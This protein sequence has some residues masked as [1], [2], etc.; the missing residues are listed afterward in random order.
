M[1]VIRRTACPRCRAV[2]GDNSGD[3]LVHYSDGGS[4][5]FTCKY[6]ILSCAERVR[7]GLPVTPEQEAIAEITPEDIEESK[8]EGVSAAFV[9]KLKAS[10][11]LRGRLY[12]GISDKSYERYWVLHEYDGRGQVFRQFYPVFKEVE[13]VSVISRFK[14]R[15]HP[16]TFSSLGMSSKMEMF[17]GE[18]SFARIN[19]SF[20]I[21]TAGEIDALSAHTMLLG[22]FGDVP[23]VCPVNG[24][25]STTQ[26]MTRR[27][28][29][30][31]R[32]EHVLL[33][34]DE[35]KAGL[36]QASVVCKDKF[37]QENLKGKL[38]DVKLSSCR[39]LQPLLISNYKCDLNVILTSGYT[40]QF[41]N[42][43]KGLVC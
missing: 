17:F 27:I 19:S 40:S 31:N 9:R 39:E 34:L 26:T 2:G 25:A 22:E 15:L 37:L 7:R 23:C 38:H 42:Y 14:V 5:C 11:T 1:A 43:I 36:E 8:T 3:N 4:R 41:V 12:R 33:I 13:G 18:L 28:E 24:E 21:I 20:C 30:L 6:T 35:D 29:F 10:T 16:K 32:F